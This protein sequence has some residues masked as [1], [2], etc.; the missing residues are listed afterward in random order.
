MKCCASPATA[1]PPHDRMMR[2]CAAEQ[3]IHDP[4]MGIPAFWNIRTAVQL[5]AAVCVKKHAKVEIWLLAGW[6]PQPQRHHDSG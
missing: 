2:A 5:Y 1:P 4:W 6:Q 3:R